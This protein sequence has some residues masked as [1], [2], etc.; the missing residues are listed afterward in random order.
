M[1]AKTLE[2]EYSYR[3]SFRKF[4]QLSLKRLKGTHDSAVRAAN[5]ETCALAGCYN[6]NEYI[7]LGPRAGHQISLAKKMG[8]HADRARSEQKTLAS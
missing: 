8:I 3:R 5:L 2:N 1:Q 6:P 7:G 4:L